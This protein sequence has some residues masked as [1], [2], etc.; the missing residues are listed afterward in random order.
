MLKKCKVLKRKIE[1]KISS[2]S[3]GIIVCEMI[4]K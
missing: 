3:I 1:K 4:M 2:V